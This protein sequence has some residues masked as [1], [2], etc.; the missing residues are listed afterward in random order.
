M[1]NKCYTTGKMKKND[2][3]S[4]QDENSAKL[5]FQSKMK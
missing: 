4:E 5:K 2:I 3:Q 1:L